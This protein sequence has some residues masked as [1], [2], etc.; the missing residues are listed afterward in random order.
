MHWYRNLQGAM[1]VTNSWPMVLAMGKVR[2]VGAQKE[3][4][5][6]V[7]SLVMVVDCVA[8]LRADLVGAKEAGSVGTAARGLVTAAAEEIMAAAE[9]GRMNS[10][11]WEGTKL[12]KLVMGTWG[13]PQKLEH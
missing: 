6:M 9:T 2:E 1:V 3:G 11:Y 4:T 10:D 7:V 5:E 8:H 12:L 13:S